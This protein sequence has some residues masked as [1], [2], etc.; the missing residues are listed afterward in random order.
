MEANKLLI[1]DFT[2][3]E[4]AKKDWNQLDLSIVTKEELLDPKQNLFTHTLSFI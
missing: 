1:M 3:K 4:K 2:W